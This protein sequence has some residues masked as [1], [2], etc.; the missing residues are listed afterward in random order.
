M[1]EQTG[2]CAF[3]GCAKVRVGYRINAAFYCHEHYEQRMNKYYE[4]EVD[5]KLHK[6][7]DKPP[8]SDIMQCAHDE[9]EKVGRDSNGPFYCSM[10]YLHCSVDGCSQARTCKVNGDPYCDEHVAGV[11]LDNTERVLV[12]CH[13]C[14]KPNVVWDEHKWYC[15]EHLAQKSASTVDHPA[16]YNTGEI[17]VVDAIMDWGLNFNLGCAVK[18]TARAGKKDPSKYVEDLEKAIRYL[19]FEI[20]WEKKH[21]RG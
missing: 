10:H 11:E 7:K 4:P 1:T 14:G 3:K 9:C 8:P 6:W 13:L 5:R 20:E 16:H 17:E 2:D 18:H 21:G 12:S 15:K 19:Q